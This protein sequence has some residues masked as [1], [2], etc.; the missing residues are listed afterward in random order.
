MEPNNPPTTNH[1]PAEISLAPEHADGVKTANFTIPNLVHEKRAQ[2]QTNSLEFATTVAS[3]AII[4]QIAAN[5][6]QKM[7][8]KKT[9]IPL[10]IKAKSAEIGMEE[11]KNIQYTTLSKKV[12]PQRR[13]NCISHVKRAK[14]QMNT[15][16]RKKKAALMNKANE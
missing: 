15:D 4:K 10:V 7:R 1:H 2:I 13:K 6:D 11:K 16:G 14:A 5:L 12:N 8:K 3:L 9:S